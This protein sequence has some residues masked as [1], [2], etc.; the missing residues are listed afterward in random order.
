V[1]LSISSSA[2]GHGLLTIALAGEID[3]AT[4]DSLRQAITE[5][6][7]SGDV[8]RIIVDLDAVTFVDSSA[9]GV[10][11]AG[12]RRATETGKSLGLVNAHGTVRRVLDL[13]ALWDLLGIEDTPTQAAPADPAT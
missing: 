1:E 3:L 5:A 13:T 12:W 2:D 6:I 8:S 7:G 4:R 9:L 10:L 11:V